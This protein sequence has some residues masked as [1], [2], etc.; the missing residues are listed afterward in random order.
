MKVTNLSQVQHLIALALSVAGNDSLLVIETQKGADKK[1]VVAKSGAVFFELQV[2]EVPGP[3]ETD[4]GLGSLIR[5]DQTS[6]EISV[7]GHSNEP[8][9]QELTKEGVTGKAAAKT[10]AEAKPASGGRTCSERVRND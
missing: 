10:Q 5:I 3:R 9:T 7:V 8:L 4:L 2:D 6:G 1:T